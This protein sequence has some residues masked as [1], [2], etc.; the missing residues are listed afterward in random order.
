VLVLYSY[1]G[2]AYNPG[3]IVRIE[4]RPAEIPA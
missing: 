4:L 1:D 3:S 2:D